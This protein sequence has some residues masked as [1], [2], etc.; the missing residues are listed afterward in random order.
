M[1]DNQNT[2]IKLGPWRK[3]AFAFGDMGC[4]FSWALTSSFLMIFYT[5]VFKI[6]AASVSV[7]MLISR[8]WDAINDPMIGIMSDRTRTKW[9]RYRPWLF[10]AVPMALFTVLTFWAHP[11]WSSGAK[12]AYMYVTYGFLVFFYTGVNIPYTALAATLTQDPKERGSLGGFR[13]TF[14]FLTAIIV[15]YIINYFVPVFGNG[16]DAR[17]YV[18]TAFVMTVLIGW[19]CFAICFFG[20]KE[21]VA[22]PPSDVKKSF[23]TQAKDA[24]KNKPYRLILLSFFLVG[25]TNYGRNAA[26]AYYF[27]YV[28][29]QDKMMATYVMAL[30]I[31]FLFGSFLSPYI[32]NYFK[33]KG[34]N[35]GYSA[36]IFGILLIVCTFISP[37]HNPAIFWPLSIITGFFNGTQAAAAYGMLPDVVEYGEWQNGYRNES[38]LAAYA[39]FFQKV[40]M[41]L[42]TAG[43]AALLSVLQ[44]NPELPTQ[45]A[46]VQNGVTYLMFLIPGII[47]VIMG[48]TFMFYKL[49]YKTFDGIVA[50]IAQKK[51]SAE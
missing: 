2:Y 10:M 7:L 14:S 50:E 33:N 27:K 5:D 4:N 37:V 39:S 42:S 46:A 30:N 17:G 22:P 26:Y 28:V 34:K 16:N 51:G 19:P 32:S 23:L 15:T 35:Y 11:D 18:M 1:N 40:G 41:A 21:V 49:D 38:F 47:C 9:G 45:T 6:S 12:L 36:I 8:L 25:V 3:I 29:G 48:I 20:T 44:Y 13:M 43:V 31:P 24:F